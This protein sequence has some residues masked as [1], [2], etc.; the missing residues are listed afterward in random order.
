MCIK[1]V[2]AREIVSFIIFTS[3]SKLDKFMVGKITKQTDPEISIVKGIGLQ[4][5]ST[6]S[7]V[8]ITDIRHGLRS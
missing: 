6:S 7:S 1:Q 3:N 5:Q 2:D 4:H 8:R